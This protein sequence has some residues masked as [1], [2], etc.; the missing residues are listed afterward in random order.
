MTVEKRNPIPEREAIDRDVSK[1]I[2][3]K[4]IEVP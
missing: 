4:Q 1:N 3:T 2:Y